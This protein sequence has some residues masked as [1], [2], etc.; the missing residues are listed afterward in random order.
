M[1]TLRTAIV[2]VLLV[3]TLVLPAQ[4]EPP[5]Q[6]PPPGPPRPTDQA[7]IDR[8]QQETGSKVRISYHAVTGKVRF[9]GTDLVHV[10]PQ[11]LEPVT[12]VTPEEAARQFLGT[13]GQLFGLTDQAQ[14]LTVM[15]SKTV[16]RGRTFVRFQQVYNGTPVLGGELIVQMDASKNV[17]SANGEVLPDLDLDTTPAIS[18]KT[19]RETA[20]AK[21][22]KDYG[23][24]V[25]ELTASEPELWVY[26]PVLLGGPGP[27]FN[28]LVWRTEVTL[29]E[30]APIN[31][32][33]LV[34]AQLGAIALHFNQIDTAKNRRTYDANNTTTLPGTL[35][36]DESNPNCTGGDSHEVAAHVYAGDTYDF[37]SAEHGRDSIDNAGMTLISTVHYRSGYDNA[38]WNG[39]QM[40]YGDAYGYP[41]ADDVV[42]HEL[43]HGVTDHESNLFYFYQ[44]GAINE[45]FSDVW[46]EFVDQEQATGNDAGDTRWEIGED[47]SGLGALRNMQDPTLFDDPDRMTSANYYCQQSELYSGKG[48]NGGVH[49][50]SGVN[51]KAAYLMTDGATFNG[52]TVT[53]LGYAKVADLY[54]EVQT[55]LLTSSADY[56]DLY[57]A[58]IQACSNLGY[59]ASDCQEVRDAVDAT[60]MNQQPTTCAAPEASICDSGSPSNLFFDDI[61]SGSG[62]WAVG[63]NQGTAYWFVPQTSSTIGLYVDDPYATSG[64]GN[65]WGFDQGD[66]PDNPG[67][68]IGGR[69]DTFLAM[70]RNVQLPAGAYLHFNHSFGFESSTPSGTNR[71]DGGILEYSTNGGSSWTNAGSLITHNGYNGTISSQYD[72]PLAGRQAFTADS[73]GYI[74]SRLDLSSLAGQNVRFRFRIGTD[75]TVYDYGWFIDDVRIYMC[76]TTITPTPPT[77]LTATA[78]SQAQIDLSWTD[79]SNNESGFKIEQS[80]NG[81]SNWTQVATVGAN[82]T[83]YSN[84]GLTC[85]TTYYYRVRAYNA[86]GDSTY[87]NTAN[88]TTLACTPG[89][90][91]CLPTPLPRVG[92]WDTFQAYNDVSVLAQSGNILWAGTS[93]GLLRWDTVNESFIRYFEEDGLGS[94]V[95]RALAIDDAGNLWVGTNGGLS[96]FDGNTWATFHTGNSGLVSNDISALVI[97]SQGNKWIATYGGVSVVNDNGTPFN[98]ADDTWVTFTPTDGLAGSAIFD[99][100]LDGAGRAWFATWTPVLLGYEARGAT[101]LDHHGTPFDKRDDTWVTFRYDNSGLTHDG[102]YTLATEGANLVWFGTASGGAY[103]LDHRGT[104]DRGDDLWTSF[105]SD[106]GLA[107]DSV[108][109]VALDGASRKWFGMVRSGH[110]VSL[111]DDGGT[112]FDKTDDVWEA[113]TSTDGLADDSVKAILPTETARVWFGFVGHQGVSGL[114]HQGTPFVKADDTWITYRADDGPGVGVKALAVDGMG[115]VWI[116]TDEGISLLDD[117]GTTSRGDDRWLH[118]TAADGLAT[119]TVTTLAVDD[120][121]RVWAGNESP[122]TAQG[123]SVLDTQGT[124]FDKSDD[125]WVV[126]READGL[127]DNAIKLIVA[128]SGSVVWLVPWSLLNAVA[129]DHRNTLA[130]KGDD[131]WQTFTTS[132]GMAGSHIET[133]I[134]RDRHKWFGHVFNGVSHLDDGGTPLNKVDDVWVIYSESDGL[135]YRGISA[136]AVDCAGRGWFGN[137]VF[138]N[139]VSILDDQGTPSKDDD[140]WVTHTEADGLADNDVN[141]IAT[142]G[143]NQVWFGHTGQTGITLLDNRGTLDKGDDI[144]ATALSNTGWRDVR[145]IVFDAQGRAWVAP[146]GGVMRFTPC[147]LFGDVNGDGDVDVD[148]IMEVASRWRITD[149]DLDWNASYD[150]DGDGIITIV[151]I[152]LVAANW[153]E[154]C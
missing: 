108:E 18:A 77:N 58:L 47:V 110:G 149:D 144:W 11:P 79:N 121:G 41:L 65:I 20:L 122:S 100:A 83:T 60:E 111:L 25:V 131:V 118:F 96:V 113:F 10:I 24:S 104:P 143:S 6:E 91:L 13:Y 125:I 75:S 23:L 114:D 84:T 85:N 112:P 7:L 72:N 88:A 2:V 27:R 89:E 135:P 31:E 86:G 12:E 21:V 138:S 130:D 117:K 101:L 51:N 19:A 39:S 127:P 38:F 59:S 152:T 43:T 35:V 40:I 74:S 132:D 4:A 71:Y 50:N 82:V 119:D 124:P 153:G 68:G 80:P 106:D 78:V 128:D 150:L 107:H 52:Y 32:L 90:D 37:Y 134:I 154:T 17:V 95:V 105:T 94:D 63:S 54:Y 46:G 16:A 81:T 5:A 8:L 49:S 142:R 33:V 57:D 28:T 44:S 137:S 151:D 34:D 62:N 45:S 146:E 22:A 93:G 14:E 136:I 99:L 129:L 147:V 87:S 102:V 55:N 148:D 139:G 116:G 76:A 70:N 30:L 69:S 120:A 92:L 53:G 97:D 103:V 36:C 9:I 141:V 1:K 145:H 98:Q 126:F 15:R 123:V 64:V 67:G 140:L 61:E 109:V 133:L 42:A 26:N 73:R 115:Y 56:A 66:D 48:D 29:L 3:I